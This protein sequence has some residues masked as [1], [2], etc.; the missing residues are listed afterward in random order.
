MAQTVNNSAKPYQKTNKERIR[1]WEK[2]F[3][4]ISISKRIGRIGSLGPPR[5]L[6]I[7]H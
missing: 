3:D 5:P 2:D 1:S 4:E 7:E 6:F